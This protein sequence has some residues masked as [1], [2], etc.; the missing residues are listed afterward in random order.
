MAQS[1]AAL[2]AYIFYGPELGKKKDA[3]DAVKEKFPG[4]EEFTFYT[5]ESNIGIVADTLLNISLFADARIVN[6][7]N[8]ELL[9]KKDEI[10]LLVSCVKKMEKKTALFL[11]SDE[12]KIAANIEDSFLQAGVPKANCRI[13]YEMF[14]REKSEWLM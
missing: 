13:F 1:S 11:F 10:E 8:A 9:K 6:V 14:E 2:N 5:G 7:K 4:A 12:I 3:V